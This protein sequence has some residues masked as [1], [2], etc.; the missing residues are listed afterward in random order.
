VPD[1]LRHF[2]F[3]SCLQADTAIRSCNSTLIPILTC[4]RSQSKWSS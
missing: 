4:R 1:Q 3:F 2:K